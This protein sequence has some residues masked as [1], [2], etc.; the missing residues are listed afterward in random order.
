MTLILCVFFLICGYFI[1]WSWKSYFDALGLELVTSVNVNDLFHS[2][3]YLIF[4]DCQVNLHTRSRYL[5]YYIE[6]TT[7]LIHELTTESKKA[8]RE[9]QAAYLAIIIGV[10]VAVSVLL[11]AAIFFMILRHRQRK[12]LGGS[13]LPDKSQW[14]TNAKLHTT[15]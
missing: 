3:L 15:T 4:W 9:Q 7:A 14:T 1:N 13:P 10:L 8:E 2:L 12:S 11:A 5:L 6:L